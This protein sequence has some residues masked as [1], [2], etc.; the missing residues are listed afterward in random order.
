MPFLDLS[1]PSAAPLKHG[2]H[3]QETEKV[4]LFLFGTRLNLRPSIFSPR[5]A[6]PSLACSFLRQKSASAAQRENAASNLSPR[7]GGTVDEKWARFQW[8]KLH[9]T[10]LPTSVSPGPRFL[11]RAALLPSFLSSENWRSRRSEVC[12]AVCPSVCRAPRWDGTRGGAEEGGG[13]GAH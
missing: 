11:W 9:T 2:L 8:S 5:S 13:E 3:F 6:P 7:R 12:S 10:F 4:I 1:T